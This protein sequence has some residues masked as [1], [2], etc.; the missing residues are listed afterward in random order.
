M[1]EDLEQEVERIWCKAFGKVPLVCTNR[2][3]GTIATTIAIDM[4]EEV[5]KRCLIKVFLHPL[6][7]AL[8]S[9]TACAE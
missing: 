2:K 3:S 4:N 6:F 9:T 1:E 8:C 7:M 5:D